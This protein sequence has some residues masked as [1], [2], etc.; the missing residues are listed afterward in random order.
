MIDMDS[1]AS[2][3][4]PC[5]SKE[6][7]RVHLGRGGGHMWHGK[8]IVAI[9]MERGGEDGI[10]ELVTR[11]RKAF[12]EALQP[13]YLPEHWSTFHFAPREFGKHSIYN[14]QGSRAVPEGQISDSQPRKKATLNDEDQTTTD[15]A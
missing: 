5:T 7:E 4:Q 3:D 14:D 8:R 1:A 2:E 9:A 6:S 12:V 10:N 13:Q 11:F 15:L